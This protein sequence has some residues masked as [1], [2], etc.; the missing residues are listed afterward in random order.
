[1]I[2]IKANIDEVII[3]NTKVDFRTQKNVWDKEKHCINDNS[4]SSPKRHKNVNCVA[5]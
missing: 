4:V 3:L 1:M 2:Q 5:T